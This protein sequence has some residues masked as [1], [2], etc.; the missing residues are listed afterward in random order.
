V[1]L[2]ASML[3]GLRHRSSDAARF[4]AEQREEA[5]R[6]PAQMRGMYLKAATLI[7]TKMFDTPTI[8]TTR[9]QTT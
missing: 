3:Y 4:I 1:E 2:L 7:E 6:R 8:N 5:D 9:G